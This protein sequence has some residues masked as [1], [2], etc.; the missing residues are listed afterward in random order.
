VQTE[1]IN[2]IG[3]T[4]RT[5]LSVQQAEDWW[6][7]AMNAF[8]NLLGVLCSPQL[9]A[10]P[11]PRYQEAV[12]VCESVERQIYHPPLKR[13]LALS[14]LIP[15]A[16]VHRLQNLFYVKGNVLVAL[17][18]PYAAKAEY[19]KGIEL[20]LSPHQFH[21][22]ITHGPSYTLTDLLIAVLLASLLL[23]QWTG[24]PSAPPN[25]IITDIA[26]V[27]GGSLFDPDGNLKID[28]LAYARTN[29]TTLVTRLLEYG[30]GV[31]PMVLLLPDAIF[32]LGPLVFSS[33][34]GG[35]PVFGYLPPAQMGET[36]RTI[37]GSSM[38]SALLLAVAKIFQ[39]SLSAP[40]ASS[41]IKLADRIPPSASLVLPLYYI[42]LSLHPSPSTYNNLGILLSTIAASTTVLDQN[43][44]REVNGQ[45]LALQYYTTGLTL[46]RS[47]PHLY[48]NIGSLLKDM[49]MWLRLNSRDTEVLLKCIE[50]RSTA[51]SCAD[52]SRGGQL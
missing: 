15:T 44:A 32:K 51:A 1:A 28:L 19:E 21:H 24:G 10:H 31:L 16:G 30:G 9:P 48:T 20:A 50:R 7:R 36:S 23:M 29:S 25:P 43:G 38:T 6:H 17:S 27:C 45:A 42:A 18:K 5:F 46:D 11:D 34:R 4:L 33:T 8:D 35:L 52:V 22:A 47:H 13:P 3:A 12:N 37:P 2:N 41:K 26:R 14:P 40:E 39:D 49:G